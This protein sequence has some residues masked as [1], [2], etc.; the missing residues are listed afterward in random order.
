[1]SL[2]LAST[3]QYSTVNGSTVQYGK[4]SRVLYS[5]TAKY[6]PG[7]WSHPAA[8]EATMESGLTNPLITI[9]C[10]YTRHAV[11][12]MVASTSAPGHKST[13]LQQTVDS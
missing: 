3:V 7:M 11:N 2:D 5:T 12:M 9:H 6:S 10:S 8:M 1:M 4:L 13:L